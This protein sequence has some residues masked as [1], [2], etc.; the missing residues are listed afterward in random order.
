MEGS[1]N[2]SYETVIMDADM[3]QFSKRIELYNTEWIQYVSILEKKSRKL[4]ALQVENKNEQTKIA[5][6]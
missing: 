6:I 4:K 2:T 1:E 5:N 3:I